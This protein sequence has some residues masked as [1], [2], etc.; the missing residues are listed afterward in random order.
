MIDMGTVPKG[1][2]H[3]IGKTKGEQVLYSFLTQIMVDAIHLTFIPVGENFLIQRLC[4]CKVGTEGFFNN[5]AAPAVIFLVHADALQPFRNH[6]EHGGRGSHVK[7]HIAFG[8]MAAIEGLQK[9]LHLVKHDRVIKTP[10]LIMNAVTEF[11][12]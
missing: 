12:P 6:A 11:V 10:F 1:F 3:A 2:E 9:T 5:D 7:Q 8:V 4:G